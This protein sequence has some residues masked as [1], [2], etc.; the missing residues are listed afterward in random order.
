[1]YFDFQLHDSPEHA[2]TYIWTSCALSEFSGQFDRSQWQPGL[3]NRLEDQLDEMDD[4]DDTYR[5]AQSTGVVFLNSQARGAELTCHTDV[6]CWVYQS[7]GGAAKYIDGYRYSWDIKFQEW[8]EGGK[9]G[10]IQ[11]ISGVSATQTPWENPPK[12]TNVRL[13]V[14]LVAYFA[15]D[16]ERSPREYPDKLV[17]QK[18]C[19]DL[20]WHAWGQKAAFL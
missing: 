6:G 10:D 9:R 3:R 19:L 2:R 1:M 8:G 7:R 4:I 11:K 12:E 14:L 18:D 5:A 20:E 16:S 17:H 13:S 15:S